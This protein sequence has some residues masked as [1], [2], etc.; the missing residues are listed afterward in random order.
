MT[1]TKLKMPGILSLDV[2]NVEILG[3]RRAPSGIVGGRLLMK[4]FMYF[5]SLSM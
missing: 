4:R 3:K 1:M 5:M 2:G